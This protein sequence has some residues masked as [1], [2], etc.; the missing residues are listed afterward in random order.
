MILS[1]LGVVFG[2]GFF[3]VT[4]AQ[5]SGFEKF[6]INTILGTNGALRISEHFQSTLHS[7]TTDS[8][9]GFNIKAPENRTYIYGIE[10]PHLLKEELEDYSEINGISELIEGNAEIHANSHKEAARII[11]FALDDHLRVSS[12]AN[13]VIF[14]DLHD[15]AV[16]KNSILIGSSLA[17][18]LQI[19]INNNISLNTKG[20]DKTYRVAGIVETG[21]SDIDKV[22]IYMHINEARSLLKIPFGGSIFQISLKNPEKAPTIANH[23]RA[24]YH[25]NANSWQERE[26]VWLDVFKALRVSAGITVFTIILISG[27]GIFNTLVMIVMEKTKEIAILR[28]MGYTRKDISSIFLLQGGIILTA[29]TVLGWIFAAAATFGISKIPLRIRGIFSTDSFVVDWNIN[30]YI[31]ASILAIF[32]V[33]VASYIPAR[34]AARLE[35]G[36]IVRGASS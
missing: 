24:T 6:F 17:K 29:G 1:L 25:H 21:I 30:H 22:R 12:L 36:N 5:T 27:L 4:Q 18:R 8:S 34:R 20:Q 33:F 11:G 23:I 35:P 31:M 15:F 2:V 7:I 3:I 10:Y 9:S 14:G 28:S 19:Q 16:H 13:Q 32:V 26:K